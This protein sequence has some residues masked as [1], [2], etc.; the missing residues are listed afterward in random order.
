MAK[1][2]RIMEFSPPSQNASAGK[3][4]NFGAQKFLITDH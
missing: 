2:E 1:R 3:C 4:F